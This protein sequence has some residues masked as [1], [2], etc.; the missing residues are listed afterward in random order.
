MYMELAMALNKA[1]FVIANRWSL[2]LKDLLYETFKQ[3][4]QACSCWA[5]SLHYF[6]DML[7][8]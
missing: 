2:P 1:E 8:G 5:L 6:C 4:S 7:S 3:T